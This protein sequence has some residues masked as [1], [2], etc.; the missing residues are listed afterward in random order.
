MLNKSYSQISGLIISFL[1]AIATLSGQPLS[2]AVQSGA[3][4]GADLVLEESITERPLV[5][6]PASEDA[7]RVDFEVPY[8]SSGVLRSKGT[9]KSY[10]I[11][12]TPGKKIELIIQPD[13]S[14]TTTSLADS[15]LNYLWKSN[16]NFI[17]ENGPAIFNPQQLSDVLDLFRAFREDRETILQSHASRLTAQELSLLQYQNEARIYSFLFYFGRQVRQLPASDSFFNFVDEID[18]EDPWAK[19]LPQNILYGYEVAYLRQKDAIQGI[20]A[21]VS[22]ISDVTQRE[23]QAAFYQV[24][25]LRELMTSPSYWSKHT[26]LFNAEVLEQVLLGQQKN[27]YYYLLE[28][29]SSNYFN[30]QVGEEAYDFKAINRAGE[31]VQLSDFKG[32]FVFI[33]NWASWCGPCLRHRPSVLELSRAFQDQPEIVFLMVSVDGTKA[34]WQRYFGRKKE[35]DAPALDLLVE[36]GMEETYGDRYNIGFIPKYVLIGPDGKILD[37]NLPEPGPGLE[38]YLKQQLQ[39]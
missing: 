19:T 39:P 13:S 32:K 11:C 16:N 25:Y 6:L 36:N 14:F 17:A 34:A 5:T 33:D 18:P 1:T 30:A 23:D 38:R 8:Y 7:P 22:F 9:N 2:I 31:E 15:L 24:M 4:E 29:P 35:A 20:P 26:Q 37:A 10:L 12:L 3:I 27:P 21:F 28:T